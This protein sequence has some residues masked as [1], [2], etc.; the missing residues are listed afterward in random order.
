MAG[1]V[2]ERADPTDGRR[3]ALSLTPEGQALVETLQPV[4]TALDEVGRALNSEAGDAVSVLARLETAMERRSIVDRVTDILTA[5][6]PNSR[7]AP[8]IM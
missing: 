6:D 8:I 5:T 1:L 3:R 2:A 4:W 7:H